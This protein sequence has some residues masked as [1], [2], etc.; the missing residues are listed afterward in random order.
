[1]G[2]VHLNIPFEEPLHASAEDIEA[3]L[4]NPAAAA[5]Q[6]K[7]TSAA[8][9][10]AAPP[11]SAGSLL[12][13]DRPG[14]VVAGPWRAPAAQLAP[15]AAALLRWQQR[16]G[17]PV[18]ADGLSGLR[19]WSGLQVVHGYDILL[20]EGHGF[21]AAP[22]LLRLGSSAAVDHRQRRPAA[23]DQRGRSPQS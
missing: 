23:V 2:P 9:H 20:A 7:A 18:L 6:P 12:D 11:A 22:Q 16:S 5:I 8:P 21:P 10:M 13:P 14:V 4:A 3:L 15:F 1:M 17:W 19:G